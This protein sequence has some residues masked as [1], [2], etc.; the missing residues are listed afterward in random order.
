MP[1]C[2]GLVSS[3]EQATA[4]PLLDR[5][6]VHQ[7]RLLS[8][9]VLRFQNNEFSWECSS[10]YA[11]ECGDRGKMI[12]TFIRPPF[13]HLKVGGH[14]NPKNGQGYYTQSAHYAQSPPLTRARG[15][16]LGFED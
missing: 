8:R 13:R 11:C 14:P 3:P 10:E 2:K 9:R 6:F 16:I 1:Q 15:G 12:G 5:G 7:E 4:F